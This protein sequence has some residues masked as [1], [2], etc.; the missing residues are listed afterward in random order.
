L[1]KRSMEGKSLTADLPQL[2]AAALRFLSVVV[3]MGSHREMFA[4]KETLNVFC[5]QIIL[6]N[7]SLRRTF[8]LTYSHDLHPLT[9]SRA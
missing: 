5:Q 8:I 4:A 2:V 3:K 1:S 6:P 7:M 9:T